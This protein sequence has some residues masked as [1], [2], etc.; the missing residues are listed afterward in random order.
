MKKAKDNNRATYF[1]IGVSTGFWKTPIS[2]TIRELSKKHGLTWLRPQMSNHRF[3]NLGEMLNSDLSKKVMMN[4]YDEEGEDRENC[5]SSSKCENGECLYGGKCR[6]KYVIYELKDS[7]TG[8][9][10]IGKTQQFLKNRTSNHIAD[11]WK[12]VEAKKKNKT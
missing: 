3:T 4:I 12:R 6:K 2:V 11:V 5:N 1:C 8:K 7:I 9:S 10:Y